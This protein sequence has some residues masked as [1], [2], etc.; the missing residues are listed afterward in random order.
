MRGLI[1]GV[2]ASTIGNTGST[3]QVPNTTSHVININ[4]PEPMKN[5]NN[6]VP[7]STEMEN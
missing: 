4:Y 6:S 5:I 3:S 2:L 1:N 7:L